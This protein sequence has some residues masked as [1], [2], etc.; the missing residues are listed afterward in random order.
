MS[1]KCRK[2]GSSHHDSRVC[3]RV[4][5][6]L[7]VC[8]FV[9]L[10]ACMLFNRRARNTRNVQT[11]PRS[12]IL[13]RKKYGSLNVPQ[14]W[15]GKTRAY[16]LEIQADRTSEA[17]P[18]SSQC[19]CLFKDIWTHALDEACGRLSEAGTAACAHAYAHAA[20]PALEFV[21]R[22]RRPM[23]GITNIYIHIYR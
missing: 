13:R 20:V 2:L 16:S 11:R 19:H 17:A 4:C 3:A 15:Q 5:V 12:A 7:C 21:L 6:C 8:A 23:R 10:H 14:A 1:T 22:D 18:H 9:C